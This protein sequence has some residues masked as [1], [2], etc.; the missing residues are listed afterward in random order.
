MARASRGRFAASRY[1]LE[2]N[3]YVEGAA[4][5]VASPE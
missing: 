3:I 2:L 4:Q 1:D 5:L